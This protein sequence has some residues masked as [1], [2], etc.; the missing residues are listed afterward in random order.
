MTVKARDASNALRTITTIKARDAD[1]VLRSISRIT[2]RDAANVLRTVWQGGGELKLTISPT[3]VFRTSASNTGGALNSLPA[4]ALVT[5][6]VAPLTYLWERID[7][8]STIVAQT[9][10]AA[11]TTFGANLN[12]DDYRVALFRC[13]VRDAM[14]ATVSQNV[15]VTLHLI[16]RSGIGGTL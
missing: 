1:N 2:M 10:T 9:P 13:T 8:D 11:S 16:D 3:E 7:G 14:G 6:G 5:G 4:T 12:P 15:Q